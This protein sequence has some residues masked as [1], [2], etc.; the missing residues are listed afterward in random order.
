MSR[1]FSAGQAG[2]FYFMLEMSCCLAIFG[3][4]H[5]H[6]RKEQQVTLYGIC[7]HSIRIVM[8]NVEPDTYENSGAAKGKW[9]NSGPD[10]GKTRIGDDWPIN[11]LTE[12]LP[13]PGGVKKS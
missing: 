9:E 3:Q 11:V 1:A 8:W 6:L 10:C 2:M 7:Q 13:F 12:D 5:R 4:R